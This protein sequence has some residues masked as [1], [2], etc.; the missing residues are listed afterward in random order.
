MLPL[1]TL[2]LITIGVGILRRILPAKYKRW[3]P[4]V[5]TVAGAVAGAVGPGSPTDGAVLG[6]GAVGLWETVGKLARDAM[7]TPESS[8]PKSE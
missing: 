5:G 7:S 1:W 6:L 8:A 4:W 3:L 2:P